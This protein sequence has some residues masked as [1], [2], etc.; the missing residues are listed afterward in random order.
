MSPVY[1]TE[2]DDGKLPGHTAGLTIRSIV[3]V[4]EAFR[5]RVTGV[6]L[7]RHTTLSTAAVAPAS[8]CNAHRRDVHL[9]EGGHGGGVGGVGLGD[10]HL[11]NREAA[12]VLALDGHAHAGALS[13][14]GAAV[15]GEVAVGVGEELLRGRGL[16]GALRHGKAVAGSRGTGADAV[17]AA[18]FREEGRGVLPRAGG[19][20]GVERAHDPQAP[21]SP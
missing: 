16:E 21:A 6:A 11:V 13:G 12:G 1:A 18:F 9:G 5:V 3:W 7:P 17:G 2:T 10:A 14:E 19:R 8:T 20:P 15:G 4:P